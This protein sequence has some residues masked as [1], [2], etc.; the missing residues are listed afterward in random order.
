MNQ[1]K[2]QL[3]VRINERTE[4]RIELLRSSLR[5]RPS[6]QETIAWIVDEAYRARAARRKAANDDARF[7]QRT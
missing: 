4:R 2:K 7:G 1:T 5:P 3:N 6:L